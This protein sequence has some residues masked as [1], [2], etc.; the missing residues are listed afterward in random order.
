M[1]PIM[2]PSRSEIATFQTFRTARMT[3][4]SRRLSG[5][6]GAGGTAGW[7]RAV[8][9]GAE[10][11]FA[12]PDLPRRAKG[13]VGGAAHGL[14][15]GRY[16]VGV[17]ADPPQHA[18]VGGLGLDVA[19]GRRIR[20]GA[21]GVLVIVAHLDLHAAVAGESV[22]VPCDRA[23][24]AAG[25]RGRLAVEAYLGVEKTHVGMAGFGHRGVA[26]EIDRCLVLEILPAE[27]VPDQR[28]LD[29][30]AGLVGDLLDHLGVLDLEEPRHVDAVVAL[31]DVG[32]AAF[33]RLAVDADDRLVAA[34]EIGR[35]GRQGRD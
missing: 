14:E 28:R 15:R 9:R 13:A 21:G 11:G 8:G 26:D 12:K 1:R 19:Y 20:A 6:A 18:A 24:A 29:L 3:G 31:Q 22:D 25:D 17:H 32:D 33:A 4:P 2:V 16:D 7:A 23:V 5:E 30:L 27:G 34:A 10:I 35:V